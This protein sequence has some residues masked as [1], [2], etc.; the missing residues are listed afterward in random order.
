MHRSKLFVIKNFKK[1][2]GSKIKKVRLTQYVPSVVVH[3]SD[4][5]TAA[6]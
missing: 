6:E 4:V 3:V 1:R 5:T 2:S